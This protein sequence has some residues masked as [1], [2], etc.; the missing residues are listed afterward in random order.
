MRTQVKYT[1]R[2]SLK[3]WKEHDKTTVT[4]NIGQF[5]RLVTAAELL[6]EGKRL[7]AEQRR[8]WR[9][10]TNAAGKVLAVEYERILRAA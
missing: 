1:L 3:N 7:T 6:A 2:F 9:R 10:I 5:E 4:V 8:N